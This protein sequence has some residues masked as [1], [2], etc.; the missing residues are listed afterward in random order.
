[1][2]LEITPPV[3]DAER[4]ALRQALTQAG[5][6]LE[7]RPLGYESAWRHAAAREAVE[8]EPDPGRYARSPRSTRGATS[9]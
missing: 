7:A 5:V 8:N 1:M 4:E 9:A 2:G 3:G 6:P